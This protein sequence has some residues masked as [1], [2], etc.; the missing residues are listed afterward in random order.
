M[1]P[2]RL[3]PTEKLKAIFSLYALPLPF[4]RL[5][6]HSLQLLLL[7]HPIAMPMKMGRS[8]ILFALSFCCSALLPFFFPLDR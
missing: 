5:F 1:R 3:L 8:N 2:I 4:A 7:G 6:C